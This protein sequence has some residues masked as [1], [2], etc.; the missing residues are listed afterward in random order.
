M[1]KHLKYF[2]RVLAENFAYSEV[3]HYFAPTEK[4]PIMSFNIRRDAVEDADCNWKHRKHLCAKV[5]RRADIVCLQE[6]MPHMA[7]YLK[8]QM[9]DTYDMY[10]ADSLLHV[11]LDRNPI[12][13]TEGLVIFYNRA[14]YR[15]VVADVLPMSKMRWSKGFLS[16]RIALRVVLEDKDTHELTTVFN[17]HLCH[18]SSESRKASAEQLALFAAAAKGNVF[19]AGDFNCWYNAPELKPLNDT[20][21]HNVKKT[22]TYVGFRGEKDKIIDM[23]YSDIAYKTKAIAVTR[24]GRNISDHHA[25][26]LTD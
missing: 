10:S 20:L 11:R 12:I 7:K 14:K 19:V 22:A 4:Y 9:G 8:A 1:L 5:M 26:V 18:K 16:P 25:I 21:H 17:T 15:L 24:N 13:F 6:V 23:I 2:G 3:N